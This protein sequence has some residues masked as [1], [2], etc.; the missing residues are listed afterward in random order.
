M[1]AISASY[2]SP[3]G[4]WRRRDEK[5]I[6]ISTL[7]SWRER[8]K[9]KGIREAKESSSGSGETKEISGNWRFRRERKATREDVAG[10][11][12]DC[13]PAEWKLQKMYKQLKIDT[14]KFVT[15]LVESVYPCTEDLPYNESLPPYI[16][17][18]PKQAKGMSQSDQVVTSNSTSSKLTDHPKY[19]I[20][21]NNTTDVARQTT[22]V[23]LSMLDLLEHLIVERTEY[24]YW[25][26]R[27]STDDLAKAI[28]EKHLY[29]IKVL[30]EVKAILA[31]RTEPDTKTSCKVDSEDSARSLATPARTRSSPLGKRK[32]SSNSS[33]GPNTSKAIKVASKTSN[34]THVLRKEAKQPTRQDQQKE[35]N[36][37]GSTNCE[38]LVEK[39]CAI[40][41]KPIS[42]AAALSGAISV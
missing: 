29:Y 22:K 28:N 39:R 1:L 36:Q 17:L 15:W 38:N 42:Y 11:Y 4:N 7:H 33:Q 5:T 19:D 6:E 34:P 31:E 40:A 8:R 37:A 23:P 13:I 10:V 32:N 21:V 12:G 14:N 30:K 24:S 3:S 9:S 41:A 16:T 27:K 25:M 18:S 20:L 26:S 2:S 35:R